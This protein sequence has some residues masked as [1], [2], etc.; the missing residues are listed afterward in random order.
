M[1]RMIGFILMDMRK[2]RIIR[3][4]Q[5][6]HRWIPSGVYNE[7][8]S[9]PNCD[10]CHKPFKGRIP[11][12]HH[13][14]PLDKGGTNTKENLMAL[15]HHCH[16]KLDYEAGVGNKFISERKFGGL[17]MELIKIEK[18][19]DELRNLIEPYKNNMDRKQRGQIEQVQNH[20]N[21][22]NNALKKLRNLMKE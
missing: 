3:N 18:T 12:V 11:E 7:L 5:D 14:I 21:G 13:K 19:L 16:E 4:Y 10:Y 8:K 9:R 1:S 15:H 20:I 6:K 2:D 22:L 17:F